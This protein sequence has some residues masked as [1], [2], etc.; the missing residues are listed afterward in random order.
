MTAF[1]LSRRAILFSCGPSSPPPP[2]PPPRHRCVPRPSV[3]SSSRALVVASSH[4][5]PELS[6]LGL[7]ISSSFTA[8]AFSPARDSSRSPYMLTRAPR[9][10][11]TCFSSAPF[12]AVIS[13]SRAASSPLSSSSRSMRALSARTD[14]RIPPTIDLPRAAGCSSRLRLRPSSLP[15]PRPFPPRPGRACLRVWT[16]GIPPPRVVPPALLGCGGR[17]RAARPTDRSQGGQ[18]R[19]VL[20]T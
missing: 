15:T 6:S 16:A 14:D 3:P 19:A 20:E 10:S 4:R 8:T 9:S 18:A 5:M 13:C 12:S 1:S 17:R 11:P 2:P 7:P